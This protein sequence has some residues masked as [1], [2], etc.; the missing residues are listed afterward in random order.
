MPVSE[1]DK[2]HLKKARVHNGRNIVN[3]AIK[4]KTIVREP[5]M[6]K[7]PTI[8]AYLIPSPVCTYILNV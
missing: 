6:I 2:K 5:S 1:F 7:V 4:I 3:I 8:V